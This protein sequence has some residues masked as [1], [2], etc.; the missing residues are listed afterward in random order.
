MTSTQPEARFALRGRR[1]RSAETVPYSRLRERARAHAGLVAL[2][3]LTGLVDLWGLGRLG[4]GNEFYAAAVKAGTQSWKAFFFGSIDPA[5][6]I[7]VDKPPASLWVMELSGRVFGFSSWSLLAPQAIEGIAAVALLYTTVRRWF[8]TPAALLSGAILAL[9]PVAALMF[10]FDNPD[11]LLVL[12]LV[13]AAYA[14]VR[15]IERAG[16]WW[17]ALAGA[18]V[19]LGFL[20]KMMQAFLVLPA[21]ALAYFVAAPASPLRRLWHLA[22]ASAALLVTGGWWVA[23]VELTPASARPYVGGSTDNSILDLIWGYNGLGRI[24]GSGAGNRGGFSGSTGILRLFN[25]QLGGQISWLIP[26]ALVVFAAGLWATLRR[27]RTDRTRAALV[28]W[29]VWLLVGALTYSYMSGIIHPY[30]SNTLAPAVA[31]LVGVGAT[32]LWSAR[33]QL[34]AAL[35]LATMLIATST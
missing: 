32:L 22:L 20:T 5:N 26:A 11:A 8:S 6:F 4:Y 16:V 31:V 25:T 21:L 2:L 27:P 23:A 35:V 19:G 33:R 24:S 34:R 30:Y 10:R 1:S 12:L 28:L 18:A 7:T 29:G 15:A 3:A 17:L 9:T 13:L 14:V